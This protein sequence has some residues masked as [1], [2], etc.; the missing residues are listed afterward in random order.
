MMPHSFIHRLLV[1]DSVPN[2]SVNFSV[3]LS[4]KVRHLRRI[5]FM[6]IGDLRSQDPTTLIHAK[7]Q[8]FPTFTP[9]FTM[10]LGV[11]FSLSTDL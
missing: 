6:S 2:E 11:P 9:L 1:I 4:Q 10:L 8:F 5:M 7:V 3:K